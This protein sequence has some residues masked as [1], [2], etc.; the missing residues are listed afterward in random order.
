MRKTWQYVFLGLAILALKGPMPAG[1]GELPAY[2][3]T[4]ENHL[5]GYPYPSTGDYYEYR[6][7]SYT[8]EIPSVESTLIE[9]AEDGMIVL[10]AWYQKGSAMCVPPDGRK[11]MNVIVMP[12]FIVR[13]KNRSS[14]M[15]SHN[16]YSIE[17]P[18][19]IFC[20]YYVKR[21]HLIQH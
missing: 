3:V 19:T 4:S 13:L 10:D 17:E 15:E 12:R 14:E 11:G 16:F 7:S 5:G 6:F 18:G 8:E 2:V 21:F 9:L 1:C 20:G